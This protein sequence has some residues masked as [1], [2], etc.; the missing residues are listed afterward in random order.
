MSTY[1]QLLIST[2][3]I[4]P[5]V[6]LPA[7]ASAKYLQTANGDHIEVDDCT[8]STYLSNGTWGHIPLGVTC[9]GVMYQG[10]DGVVHSVDEMKRLSDKPMVAHEPNPSAPTIYSRSEKTMAVTSSQALAAAHVQSFSSRGHSTST[11]QNTQAQS[12]AGHKQRPSATFSKPKFGMVESASDKHKTRASEKH[13]KSKFA[14]SDVGVGIDASD[15]KEL[16]SDRHRKRPSKKHGKSKFGIADVEIDTDIEEKAMSHKRRPSKKGIRT[17]R[18]KFST[19]PNG[20]PDGADVP[21]SSSI[22][23][24][25]NLVTVYKGPWKDKKRAISAHRSG[26]SA[27]QG[28]GGNSGPMNPN[29]T[30]G[31]S[32]HQTGPSGFTPGG[33]PG[34]PMGPGPTRGIANSNG[35]AIAVIDKEAPLSRHS[36]RA[37]EPH[38]HSTF[39]SG[40]VHST[41]RSDK[42]WPDDAVAAGSHRIGRSAKENVHRFRTSG[43]SGYQHY[44]DAKETDII[45]V[46]CQAPKLGKDGKP[47]PLMLTGHRVKR[48]RRT[49]VYPCP[50]W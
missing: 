11:S 8:D 49:G 12:I 19:G 6:F 28:G 37:S 40:Y 45:Q 10:P 31:L 39:R 30:R 24:H 32:A 2:L 22:A 27:F 17:E 34:G 1:K 33:P 7:I 3:I 20:S 23:K 13:G 50:K 4:A 26:P 29:S 41:D 18:I 15:I 16:A 43:K 36:T 48:T 44:K 25:N 35:G 9:E 47:E 46:E 42:P 21:E 14:V 38:V 5:V